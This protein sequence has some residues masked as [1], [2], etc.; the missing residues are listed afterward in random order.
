ML[1]L[2]SLLL[3]L[4]QDYHNIQAAAYNSHVQE[5]DKRTTELTDSRSKHSISSFSRGRASAPVGCSPRD[6]GRLLSSRVGSS[7]NHLFLFL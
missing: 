3:I 2:S 7:G 1:T 5:L 6:S 4:L